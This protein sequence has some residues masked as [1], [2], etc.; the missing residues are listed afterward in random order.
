MSESRLGFGNVRLLILSLVI[1]VLSF[2][3]GI[4]FPNPLIGSCFILVTGLSLFGAGIMFFFILMQYY[5][6]S[7]GTPTKESQTEKTTPERDEAKIGTTDSSKQ[8]KDKP[9]ILQK[10]FKREKTCNE[11]GTKL[12]YRED[13]QSYYCPNCRTYKSE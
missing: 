8:R 2:L 11:C 10:L 13:Y 7:G 3:V 6:E 1:A 4:F 5:S 12:E 9:G